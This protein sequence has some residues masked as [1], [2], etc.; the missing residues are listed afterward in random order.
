MINR[1]TGT[2]I[3][4]ASVSAFAPMEGNVMYSATKSFLV[5][6]SRALQ[7]ETRRHGIQVQALCPGFFHSEFHDVAQVDKMRIPG[8]LFMSADEVAK[9]ALSAKRRKGVIYV[10]GFINQLI[11]LFARLPGLGDWAIE[12]VTWLVTRQ[13]KSLL[14]EPGS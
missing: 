8:F 12:L 3:N 7:M 2:I 4:V 10:P 14:K 13:R 1:R 11:V 5:N 9:R 6:F